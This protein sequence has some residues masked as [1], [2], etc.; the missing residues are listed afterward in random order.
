LWAKVD[1]YDNEYLARMKPQTK[2]FLK[3]WLRRLAW[4]PLILVVL[5]VLL[6]LFYRNQWIDT[7]KRELNALNPSEW[8]ANPRKKVLVMGDSFSAA[9]NSW[10]NVLRKRHSDWNIVNSAVPGTTIYQ[11][12][13]MVRGR[14]QQFK[15]DILVYQIYAG[16][17]LFDLHYPS[18]WKKINWARNS[19]WFAA[20]HLRSLAWLN[21]TLGQLKRTAALPDFEQG[22]VNEGEFDPARYSERERL[23]LQAEPDLI[24]NQ[25]LLQSN[26]LAHMTEYEALLAEFLAT[27]K[28]FNC[29][30]V[31][32]VVPHCAQVRVSYAQRMARIGAT[33][34][35]NP[36]LRS[37]KYPFCR[38]LDAFKTEKVTILNLLPAL[39]N[40][41]ML[42]HTMYYLHDAHLNDAGQAMVAEVVDSLL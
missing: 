21:Y 27:A 19:Y 28:E 4:V 22:K 31:L 16:N 13:L 24:G 23:Y 41:E 34:M 8:P 26:R 15:P 30:V 5:L 2:A 32:M 20:N 6:E 12:N 14:I 7:Y 11:A 35:G 29:P 17:D 18:N 9:E 40:Q 10:V 42:G 39:Q 38:R 36:A 1:L 3:K 37:V 25:V 33:Q